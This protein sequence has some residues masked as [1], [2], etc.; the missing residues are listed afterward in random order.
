MLIHS[1]Q[2]AHKQ[3][4]EK[5]HKCILIRAIHKSCEA[6]HLLRGGAQ[7]QAA[8]FLVKSELS[9]VTCD[10]AKHTRTRVCVHA[11][12]YSDGTTDKIHSGRLL[13]WRTT[14][15]ADTHNITQLTV[16]SL[17]SEGVCVTMICAQP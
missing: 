10:E 4:Q 12:C 13:T 6:A 3:K 9:T 11:L 17:L 15:L 8:K 7:S 14:R 5:V 1:F 2:C 16:F